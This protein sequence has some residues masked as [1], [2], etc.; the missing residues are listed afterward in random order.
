MAAIQLKYKKLEEELLTLRRK[1]RSD[2]VHF[3][4]EKV[5]VKWAD[6]GRSKLQIEARLENSHQV[7][8]LLII[9]VLNLSLVRSVT[10]CCDSELLAVTLL[11]LRSSTECYVNSV[12]RFTYG[13]IGFEG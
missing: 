1:V 3:M 5:G 12:M 11:L 4:E 9:L 10:L 2:I 6:L 8:C 13:S 7:H